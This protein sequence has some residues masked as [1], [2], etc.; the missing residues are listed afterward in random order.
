MA[1]FILGTLLETG[2]EGYP[3][4]ILHT[5]Q[6]SVA[7]AVNATNSWTRQFTPGFDKWSPI[8]SSLRYS[9]LQYSLFSFA[10][11][12]I[13]DHLYAIML[14]MYVSSVSHY[15]VARSGSLSV[16]YSISSH[17]RYMDRIWEG[18][19]CD[20]VADWDSHIVEWWDSRYPCYEIV[21]NMYFRYCWWQ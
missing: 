19:K 7:M 5:L 4:W 15:H 12:R 10:R 2:L 18:P 9:L 21:M 1:M 17:S 13:N 16:L 8:Y 20:L 14:A 11:A 6:L 3:S